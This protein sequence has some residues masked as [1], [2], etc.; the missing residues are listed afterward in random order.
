MVACD[1]PMVRLGLASIIERE[2]DMT[3]IGQASNAWEAKEIF[4]QQQPDVS[5]M[6]LRLLKLSGVA[7]IQTFLTKFD[8]A[9]ILI[10]TNYDS[11][12]DIYSGIEAGAKGYLH[13]DSEPEAIKSAIRAVASGKSYI[14]PIVATKLKEWMKK[15]RLSTRELEILQLITN[16]KRN[17]EIATTLYV[18]EGT[19]KF[20]VTKILD[21]LEV[22]DRTQAVL[23]AIKSG[24]VSF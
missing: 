3:V 19:V 6:N 16:G 14:S 9:N 1:Y 4:C 5:V 18:T 8:S 21:K 15:P 20:H 24:I 13:E 7:T 12:E 2:S 11:K 10:S 23:T 17:H 22:N